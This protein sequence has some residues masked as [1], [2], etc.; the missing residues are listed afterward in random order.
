MQLAMYE[1][2]IVS[3]QQ[4]N[5]K[6]KL[7]VYPEMFSRIS[8]G[9]AAESVGKLETEIDGIPYWSTWTSPPANGEGELTAGEILGWGGG[10]S[11]SS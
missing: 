7:M 10:E 3:C 4:A 9:K 1:Y 2:L 11:E 5:W 8:G 6:L